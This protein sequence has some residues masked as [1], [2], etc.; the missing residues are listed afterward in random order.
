MRY[1]IK[2]FLAAGIGALLALPALGQTTNPS[3]TPQNGSTVQQGNNSP[4]MTVT[5]SL[6]NAMFNRLYGGLNT[7]VS[8]T[9]VNGVL[10]TQGGSLQ[11][12][13]ANGGLGAPPAPGVVTPGSST[14]GIYSAQQANN[15]A[16]N[17]I[18]ANSALSTSPVQTGTGPAT[19]SIGTNAAQTAGAA[20][21][22]AA[23]NVTGTTGISA[24]MGTFVPGAGV[25]G[26]GASTSGTI[27]QS[28]GRTGL[29]NTQ[30]S[31]AQTNRF[32]SGLGPTSFGT[33][34]SLGTT[35]LNT[36]QFPQSTLRI[37]PLP[38]GGVQGNGLPANGAAATPGMNGTPGTAPAT[39]NS[40][41]TAG[42]PGGR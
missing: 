4:G 10:P 14:S 22:G 32:F 23:N 27:V 1:V 20:Q 15:A 3:A 38:T 16:I 5:Q 13:G 33:Q 9:G 35:G 36:T 39:G 41:G 8:G 11:P 21:T 19:S 2:S 25:P 34:T 37:S 26:T 30:I 18:R 31:T 17:Q 40:P 24:P 12:G 42:R 28:A 6:N 7:A 29:G